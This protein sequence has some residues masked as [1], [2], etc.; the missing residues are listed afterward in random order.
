MRP[1]G[2]FK[3]SGWRGGAPPQVSEMESVGAPSDE[4]METGLAPSAVSALRLCAGGTRAVPRGLVAHS[5][6]R[7]CVG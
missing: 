5:R 1:S 7:V 3:C 2:G 4:R 6:R